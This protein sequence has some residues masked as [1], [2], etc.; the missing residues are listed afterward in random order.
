MSL[1][2]EDTI[3]RNFAYEWASGAIVP[4]LS[5]VLAMVIG[6]LV[7]LFS[8]NDPINAYWQLVQGAFGGPYNISETLVAAIPYIFAGLAIAFAFRAG[9]FNIGAQGQLLVGSIVSAWIGYSLNVPGIILIPLAL[10]GGA[11][12]GA[13]WGGVCGFLKAWRGA[14][15]VITTMMLNY[16]ALYLLGYLVESTPG[17]KPGP[18]QQHLQPG[19]PETPAV[20]A[21][22]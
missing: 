17:G 3:Q 15:E 20:N 11:L 5:V 10:A 2:T 14:H 18:M 16:V 1:T 4:I 22:L 9:L 13:V 19:F 7:V 6:A 12:A 8:G 21:M